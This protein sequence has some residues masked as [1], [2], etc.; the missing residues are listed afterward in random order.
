M[1][2]SAARY[3]AVPAVRCIAVIEVAS[4]L[5]RGWASGSSPAVWAK[6][7]VRLTL[8]CLGTRSLLGRLVSPSGIRGCGSRRVLRCAEEERQGLWCPMLFKEE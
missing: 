6:K 1:G 5:M 8:A 7:A 3:Y 4:D 2:M